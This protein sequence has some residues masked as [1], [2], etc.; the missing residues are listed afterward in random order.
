MIV[1]I[2]KNRVNVLLLFIAKSAIFQLHLGE[3]K[4]HSMMM[5]SDLN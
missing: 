5:M 4:L 1:S 2:I 3:N